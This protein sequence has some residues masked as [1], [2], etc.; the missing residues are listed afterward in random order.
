MQSEQFFPHFSFKYVSVSNV[1]VSMYV[2]VCMSV[3]DLNF[4]FMIFNN[5]RNG[6]AVVNGVMLK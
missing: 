3:D 1:S 6:A 2:S 5:L 4:V